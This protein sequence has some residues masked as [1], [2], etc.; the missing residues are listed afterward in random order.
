MYSE[1]NLTPGFD[2]TIHLRYTPLEGCSE[3]S[4]RYVIF[5]TRERIRC[6]TECH[7]QLERVGN[8][9]RKRYR[10]CLTKIISLIAHTQRHSIADVWPNNRLWCLNRCPLSLCATN[11]Q[12]RSVWLVSFTITSWYTGN[13]TSGHSTI[14]WPSINSDVRMWAQTCLQ[15]QKSEIQQHTVTPFSTFATPDAQFHHTH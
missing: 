2:F 3:W 12:T 6:R 4:I 8:H 15:R 9:T 14:V 7:H 1:A 13:A 11:L 10:T 5:P